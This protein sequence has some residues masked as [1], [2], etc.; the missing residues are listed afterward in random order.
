[1][2]SRLIS[3]SQ[4]PAADK[5]KQH[6]CFLQVTMDFDF[7]IGSLDLG[8]RDDPGVLDPEVLSVSDSPI[9]VRRLSTTS[10]TSTALFLSPRSSASL[11][12]GGG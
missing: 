11:S 1:L 6:T 8:D 3:S 9:V 5:S 4:D 10:G 12:T 2:T 7:H